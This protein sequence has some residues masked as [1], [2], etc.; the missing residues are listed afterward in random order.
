MT[1]QELRLELL[2]LVWPNGAGILNVDAEHFI[3]KA[4][5]LEAYVSEEDKPKAPRKQSQR[6]PQHEHADNRKAS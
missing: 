4:R 1:K 3:E 2:R 5:V 6:T